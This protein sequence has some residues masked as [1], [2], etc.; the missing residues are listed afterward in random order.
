MKQFLAKA[1]A[2]LR[3]RAENVIAGLLGIMFVAFIAQIVARYFFNF[4]TGWMSELTVVAWLWLV[5]W[6]SAFVLKESEEIRFDLVYSSVGPRTRRVMGIVMAVALIVLYAAALPAT[7]KYVA[8]MK[9]ERTNYLHIRLDVLYS[10]YVIFAIAI[11]I[12]YVWLLWQ[13]LRGKDPQ[14]D[15]ALAVSSGL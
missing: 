2:W 14:A 1:G 13:L 5:L 9:V 11:I 8:F 6:G 7:V 12:R 10:I 15:N 4:P 3:C